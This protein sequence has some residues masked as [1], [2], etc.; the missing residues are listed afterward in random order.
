MRSFKK[1]V[2]LFIVSVIMCT[3][4]AIGCN[5]KEE[6][7]ETVITDPKDLYFSSEVFTLE[8]PEYSLSSIV[9]LKDKKAAI[10]HKWLEQN[11]CEYVVCTHKDGEETWDNIVSLDSNGIVLGS[12]CRVGENKIAATTYSGFVIFDLDTG[13]EVSRNDDL[14]VYI[15]GSFPQVASRDDGFVVVTSDCIYKISETGELLASVDYSADAELAE[16]VSFFSRN[17]KDYLALDN[18]PVMQYYEVDYDSGNVSYLCNSKELGLDFSTVYR[19]AGYA[20]DQDTGIIYELDPVSKTKKEVSYL[21]NMLIRPMKYAA[22]SDPKWYILGEHEYAVYYWYSS[23]LSEIVLL[24]PDTTS[25]LPQRTKLAI[26]GYGARDDVALNYAAYKYNTSQDKFLIT[27]E[28]YDSKQYG[29][30][31]AV[32]AQESKLKLLKDFSSGNAPDIFYGNNF[33]YDQMGTSGL[34]MDL[35]DYLQDNQV[36]NGNTISSNIYNLYFKDGHCY[37]LFPSYNMFGLW[38]NETFTANNTNMSLDDM[39]ASTYSSKIFGDHYACDIADFAI[40]YPIRRLI[41]NGDFISESELEKIIRFAID[42]GNAPDAENN[43][44]AS[45]ITVADKKNS[46]YLSYIGNINV[47]L[48]NQTYMKD[49]LRFVGFPTLNGSSHVAYPAGLVA[50]SA[51]TKYPEECMKFIEILFSDEVQKAVLANNQIPA[52]K[53]I[54]DEVLDIAQD[55]S[56]IGNDMYYS[57]LFRGDEEYANAVDCSSEDIEAY[58]QATESV[59]TVMINDWGL[60]NII[61]EEINSYYLQKRDIKDIAHSMRARIVLYLDENYT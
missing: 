29:Y 5:S 32:E 22:N 40:R 31:T 59:D 47:F 43:N 48:N 18:C 23:D 9:K 17:G 26:K 46:V 25:N 21:N 1:T 20:F 52:K 2:T 14:F 58:R 61:V 3:S 8:V 6:A 44:L 12:F 39:S 37:K 60:Y 4:L 10:Y 51:G 42:N 11:Q 28:N 50:V 53:A 27:V 36:I 57:K 7:E 56:K 38:S 30:N 49:K 55:R 15:D 24:T 41:D 35:S 33:D 54:Y 16:D 19:T 45:N 34:V 13:K